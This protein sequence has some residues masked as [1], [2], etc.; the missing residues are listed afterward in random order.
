MLKLSLFEGEQKH[1][2][3]VSVPLNAKN[4][5]SPFYLLW[6]LSIPTLQMLF[7]F[8]QQHHT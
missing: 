7:M 3:F 8:K 5:R 6:T 4:K 1:T 2:V